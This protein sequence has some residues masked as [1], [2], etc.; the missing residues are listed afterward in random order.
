[1]QLTGGKS[2]IA[3]ANFS[4]RTC[5]AAFPC[6]EHQGLLWLRPQPG[7]M[8]NGFSTGQLPGGCTLHLY[9]QLNHQEC[10]YVMSACHCCFGPL[11]P[12]YVEPRKP[13]TWLQFAESLTRGIN[14]AGVPELERDGWITND[15][16]RDFD[17][18]YTLLLE[19][20]HDPDHGLFAHQASCTQHDTKHLSHRRACNCRNGISISYIS[21]ACRVGVTSRFIAEDT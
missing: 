14:A 2:G 1:V 5:T 7:E 8:A 3:G 11:P 17:V 12:R 4:R 19:N 20:L 13:A 9:V 18:D 16:V 6:M 15:F 10:K 21:S